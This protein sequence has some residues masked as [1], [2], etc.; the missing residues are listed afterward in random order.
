MAPTDQERAYIQYVLASNLGSA[1][2]NNDL[3]IALAHGI[4]NHREYEH[5]TALNTQLRVQ[6]QQHGGAVPGG[7]GGG[8]GAL[9]MALDENCDAHTM[10]NAL[11]AG[12]KAPR[13]D[14]FRNDYYG[15]VDT[16]WDDEDEAAPC[17][18]Y[19]AGARLR[20]FDL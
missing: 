1:T 13:L 5:A 16:S 11:A 19:A 3:E 17:S 9:A 8:S 4:I 2:S 18:V 7:V 12:R 6:Q 15:G 14:E 10:M 20:P